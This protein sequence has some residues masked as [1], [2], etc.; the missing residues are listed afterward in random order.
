MNREDPEGRKQTSERT[1]EMTRDALRK[2]SAITLRHLAASRYY[3]PAQL[4]GEALKAATR[5]EN[6]LHHNELELALDEAV[7]LGE[8]AE[9]NMAYWEEL[10][11]AAENMSLNVVAARIASRLS[12]FT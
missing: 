6:F 9:G 12:N 11:L 5:M 2:S 3:L 4:E 1:G 7:T 8:L 10:R